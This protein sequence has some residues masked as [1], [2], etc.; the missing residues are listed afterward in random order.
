MTE[1]MQPAGKTRLDRL[2]VERGLQET[3][4]KAQ[5]IIMSG[6]VLVD[7]K[8]IEKAGALLDPQS[9]IE[10]L[11]PPSRY[12]GRG[13]LKLEAALDAFAIDVKG[14][15]F[16][17]IGSSTGGFVDCLLQRGA[18]RV[19]A[20][21]A[22]T[23]QMDFRLRQDPRVRLHEQTNARHLHWDD[24]GEIVDG[25]T[26][27]VAF[28]SATLVLPPLV[29]FSKPG[30]RLIVL[31]KPQFEVGK[32][33]VGRGGIVRDDRLRLESAE[34]VRRCAAALGF[35]E[36]NELPCPVLGAEGNREIFITATYRPGKP[37]S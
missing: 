24:I 36:F 35:D 32:G 3:R 23:N 33:Q 31:V 7:G 25:I 28:I 30:T 15:V 5:A 10:I 9:V 16:L 17:D 37:S 13:G 27:D 4:Q 1:I 2:L 26:V 34:K 20:V 22:G 21:D 19:I 6:R 8:K 14:M 12:V 18:V 11:G 29:Q